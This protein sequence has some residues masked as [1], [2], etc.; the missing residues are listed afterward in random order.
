MRSCS[1]LFGLLESLANSPSFVTANLVALLGGHLE[2]RLS[3]TIEIESAS[4][5]VDACVAC[6]HWAHL[7]VD[8][9]LVDVV[10]STREN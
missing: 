3:G 2:E 1:P 7:L 5:R 8:R 10:R 6:A 9:P 4:L